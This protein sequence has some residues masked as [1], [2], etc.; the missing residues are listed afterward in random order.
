MERNLGYSALMIICKLTG[1]FVNEESLRHENTIDSDNLSRLEL[2]VLAKKI[3]FKIQ[4]FNDYKLPIEKLKLPCIAINKS[5]KYFIISK[6]NADK[7]LIF[8]I[9]ENRVREFKHEDFSDYWNGTVYLLKH[10]NPEFRE[11]QFGF[12]WFI[13]TIIKYKK[14]LIEV[15]VS[16][17]TVQLL[18]LCS[19]IMT[20]IVVDKVLLHNSLTTLNVLAVGLLI[21]Y[22]FQLIMGIA[23]SYV[24]NHTTNKIDVILNARLFD[25][26]LKL[27]LR[28]FETRRV[29]DTVARV[30][31]VENIRR[32]LT[33]TPMTCV[34]DVAFVIVY[35]LVMLFYS[36]I[37]TAVNVAFIPI[38]I[39]VSVIS[40][41]LFKKS[42]NERFNAGAESQSF[43]VESVTGMNTI[44]SLA[45]EPSIRRRWES[46]QAKYT[47]TGLKT[48]IISGN[49]NAIA[50]FIQKVSD[51]IVL[52]MGA[53]L[54]IKRQ[55]SVGQLVAFRML[56]GNVS[57]PI[58]RFVQVWQD[59][60]QTSVSVKRI[61]DIFNSKSEISTNHSTTRPIHVNGNIRFENVV[62]RY[63]HNAPEVIR[64][65]SFNIPSGLSVGIVGKSGSGKS[66][67]AKLIQ[68]LYLPEAGKIYIDN[69]NISVTDIS[70][71]RKR[72]G[73]VLQENFLFNM[74]IR[75]NISINEPGASIEKIINVAKIA[76]AHDFIVDF[77]AGYDT[78]VGEQGV[79]LSG[80]QKQRIAIARALLTNPPILIFDEATSALDYES[81]RII[82][83]NLK[84]ISKNRTLLIIAHR[85]ST[86]K[87][88]D[89]IMSIDKGEIIEFDK[90]EI[91]L[92][93][94]GLYHYLYSQQ[95]DS[96]L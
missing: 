69:V 11:V 4:D 30:R 40:T 54:V 6:A 82:Q 5:N 29:G 23:K 80:G 65:M 66:T 55:L 43:L 21:I 63:S 53:Q 15:L 57:G 67:L 26:L 84:K 58:L 75:E 96:R 42:L 19:P 32:F 83:E 76:G 36:P 1:V 27:P 20:Q 71:L 24:F 33:G 9:D 2:F 87:D 38:F 70:W 88:V 52:W 3:G 85:L 95:K 39:I 79:G 17:F 59:F 41:P 64:N 68:R 91:L 28:Y 81:E 93:R 56:A 94:D 18:G 35:I 47:L 89:L 14:L 90:P 8:D 72:I 61:A 46:L 22:L 12:K 44:K 49:A 74:T 73:V 48:A 16:T 60:Q 78:P 92:K 77:P 50:Q 51:L 62:F 34:L 7:V 31:E 10:R 13:P 25:H 86:L 37:L 45:L